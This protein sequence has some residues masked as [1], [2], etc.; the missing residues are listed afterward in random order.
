ME[1]WRLSSW[2]CCPTSTTIATIASSQHH[3]DWCNLQLRSAVSIWFIYK[4]FLQ[5]NEFNG[6]FEYSSIFCLVHNSANADIFRFLIHLLHLLHFQVMSSLA[7]NEERPN[8]RC[9]ESIE[10]IL[11]FFNVPEPKP[12]LK[13]IVIDAGEWSEAPPPTMK[14]WINCYRSIVSTK[15]FCYKLQRHSVEG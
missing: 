13:C 15:Q 9:I 12:K 6:I 11:V 3:Y 10:Y 2:R 14:T 7:K 4:I 1:N 5:F 8:K